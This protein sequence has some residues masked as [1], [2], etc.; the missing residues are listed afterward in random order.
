M[1]STHV[2]IHSKD[3]K[4]HLF[5]LIVMIAYNPFS[6]KA[7]ARTQDSSFINQNII[8]VGQPLG[9]VGKIRVAYE[10]RMSETYGIRVNYS[11]FY[12]L[13]MGQHAYLEI[14]KYYKRKYERFNYFKAGLGHSFE[15][16]GSYGI[17]GIGTGQK[18]P[19]G[20]KTNFSLFCTQGIK[21]CPNI[22]GKHDT[23]TGGFG[24]LFYFS[25]PGAFFDITFNLAYT[26]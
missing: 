15:S 20:N 19:L 12:G 26:F 23:Q 4:H 5:L 18:I 21:F 25:G 11:L 24:G 1:K 17:I 8:Y 7:Y 2:C 16:V 6:N 13:N 14:R 3:M 10:N 22:I 9:L